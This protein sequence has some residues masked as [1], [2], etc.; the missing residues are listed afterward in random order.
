MQ[1]ELIE[2]KNC[3]F[4][5]EKGLTATDKQASNELKWANAKNKRQ[6]TARKTISCGPSEWQPKIVIEPLSGG[7]GKFVEVF[8][9]FYFGMKIAQMTYF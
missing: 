4:F 2:N 1:N 6:S 3:F 8:V 5:L 9:H 7:N